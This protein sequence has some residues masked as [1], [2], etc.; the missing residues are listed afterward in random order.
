MPTLKKIKAKSSH[1]SAL[2]FSLIIL[3]I[4]LVSALA[5]GAASVIDRKNSLT[6]NSS[7]Q[8]FQAADSGIEMMI[9]AIKGKSGA[10][11][12]INI[13][14]AS[15][16]SN[17]YLVDTGKGSSQITMYDVNNTQLDCNADISKLDHV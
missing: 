2:V 12:G 4:I 11:R 15:C 16:N 7:T 17:T 8:S 13:G 9:Q 5:I 6:G 3:S 1:G 10:F 14:S